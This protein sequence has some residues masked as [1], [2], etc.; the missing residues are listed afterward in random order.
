M[1][2][3]TSLLAG[4]FALGLALPAAAQTAALDACREPI[5]PPA[6]DGATATEGLMKTQGDQVREFLTASDGYQDCLIKTLSDA[7]KAAQAAN[8][9][10]DARLQLTISTKLQSNQLLKERVGALYNSAVGAY[11]KKHP[12]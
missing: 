2:A 9:E 1:T 7:T 4:L 5:V 12:G 3:K 6:V 11:K 10:V 8:T